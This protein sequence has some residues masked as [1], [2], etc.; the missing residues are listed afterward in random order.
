MV[1]TE[2]PQAITALVRVTLRNPVEVTAARRS[3][4][5]TRRDNCMLQAT[6]S[7]SPSK[8]IKNMS[9]IAVKKEG[10]LITAAA[11]SQ[12]NTSS[13]ASYSEH[14]QA[15]KLWAIKLGIAGGVGM[16]QNI[17]AWQRF[18]LSQKP[19]DGKD[20]WKYFQDYR[21]FLKVHDI[22]EFEDDNHYLL[23][24]AKQILWVSDQGCMEEA[25]DYLALG[26]GRPW[27]EATLSLGKSAE[28]AVKTAI[29]FDR[30]SGGEVKALT[31]PL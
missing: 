3:N 8:L 7:W 18:T 10:N 13:D 20:A 17:Q 12:F 9:T 22:K 19:F 29:K 2:V 21:E 28:I 14:I 6:P 30:Y 24:F 31:L 4:S 16:L 1:E 27:A 5:L 11:D 15:N 26:S 25:K 23:I